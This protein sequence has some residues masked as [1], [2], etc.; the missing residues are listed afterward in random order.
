M[1]SFEN[2]MKKCIDFPEKKSFPNKF[3]LQFQGSTNPRDAHT[4]AQ[5]LLLDN[6]L[7]GRESRKNSK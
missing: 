5:P 6:N 2:L 7:P 3:C 4:Q 1:E